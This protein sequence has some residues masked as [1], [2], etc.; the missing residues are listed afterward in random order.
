MARILLKTNAIYEIA[1][2]RDLDGATFG[3]V[4]SICLQ[5]IYICKYAPKCILQTYIV[6]TIF[7]SMLINTKVFMSDATCYGYVVFCL[8]F[9]PVYSECYQRWLPCYH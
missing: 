8:R 4:L 1:N 5:K 7:I 2:V 3:S 9:Y 6:E